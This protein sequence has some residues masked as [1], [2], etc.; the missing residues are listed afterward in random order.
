MLTLTRPAVSLMTWTVVLS[1]PVGASCS[2]IGRP[3]SYLASGEKRSN[4]PPGK[5]RD[6][7]PAAGLAASAACAD[8]ARP[9]QRAT[10]K[11][12]LLDM[13]ALTAARSGGFNTS[14]GLHGLT[15]RA[16]SPVEN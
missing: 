1:L 16:A 15:A 13:P 11:N 10:S 4:A 14:C 2:L 9:A 8:G 6:S 7:A 3:S 12:P 5:V